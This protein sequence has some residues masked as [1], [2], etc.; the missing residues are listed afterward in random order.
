MKT[1]NKKLF[2]FI[3]ASKGSELDVFLIS[4]AKAVAKISQAGDYKLTEY[5]LKLID[6]ILRQQKVSP[7]QL[8]GIIAVTG[9]GAFTSLRISAAV[10]NALAYSLQIPV[11]GIIDKEGSADNEKLVKLGLSKLSTAKVA[12]YISPFYDREPN[13]TFA[14]K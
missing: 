5:L 10:A 13:I 3:N 1:I 2:L 8:K 14:K 11:V 9:P 7:R 12:K 6:Q 4:G